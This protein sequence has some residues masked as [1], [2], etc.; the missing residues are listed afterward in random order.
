[1]NHEIKIFCD[2]CRR[3]IAEDIDKISTKE[4]LIQCPYCMN[5]IKNP[6]YS[7]NF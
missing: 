7:N 5:F 4:R 1:M 6:K 3:I 2:K